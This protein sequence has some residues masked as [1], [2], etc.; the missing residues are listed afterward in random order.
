MYVF[1]TCKITIGDI[2]FYSVNDVVIKQSIHSIAQTASIRIPLSARLHKEGQQTRVEA[3]KVFKV[4]DGVSIELGYNGKLYPEFNGYVTSITYG[5]PL[6]IECED[7]CYILRKRKITE[8]RENIKLKEVIDLCLGG[9][10]Q[11]EGDVPDMVINNFTVSDDSAINILQS[12][13]NDYGLGI[14]FTPQAKLYTGL[15]YGYRSGNV[16]YNFHKNINPRRNEL[17]YLSEEDVKI[18]ISAKS[19]KKDGG[20]IEASVGDDDGQVR[21]LWFYDIED[22]NELKNRATAEISKYK[23]NGYSGYFHSMLEPYAEIGMI[24]EITDPDFPERGGSYYIESI[25]TRFGVN[26]AS[27]KIEPGIK[28]S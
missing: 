7:H 21:T 16:K 15:I 26:G 20:L 13:K 27:R 2:V 11:V 24:A 4:G 22:V 1:L 17:K 10:Y 28:I 14:F 23:Y 9:L 5:T 6:T 25:E 8:S 18:K 19:W 12:I 3:A